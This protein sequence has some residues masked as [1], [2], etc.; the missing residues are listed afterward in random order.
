MRDQPFNYFNY[1]T[2][3]EEHFIQRR[4]KHILLSP[5]DW[6]LMEAWQEMGIPLHVALR[7]IDRAMDLFAAKQIRQRFVNSL[8][9][10]NQAVLEEHEAHLLSMEGAGSQV[11]AEEPA[12]RPAPQ[13]AADSLR[14]FL[15]R[16]HEE[17]EELSRRHPGGAIEEAARRVS[18]RLAAVEGDLAD[19]ARIDPE[20]LEADLAA[21][22]EV[23]LPALEAALSKEELSALRDSCQQELKHHRRNLGKEMYT[24][25][26]RN[27]L[28][29]R[30]K[31]H[32]GVSDLS[33]LDVQ[34]H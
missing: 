20:R 31:E 9:Y 15:T 4:G 24:R 1:F 28:R 18:A 14:R 17:M 16:R 2:E 33:L 10:C 22:D 6:T 13:A 27:F 25:I 3:I 11:E 30:I 32:F 8:F 7:G 12:E 23:L 26:L 19:G 21:M 34:W 29:K 5:L